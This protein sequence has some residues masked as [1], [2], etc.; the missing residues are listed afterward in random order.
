MHADDFAAPRRPAS[1][2]HSF[3]QADFRDPRAALARWHCPS[4]FNIAS[5]LQA[6]AEIRRASPALIEWNDNRSSL[7]TAEPAPDA[8]DASD[9]DSAMHAQQT[10][11]TFGEVIA[12][13]VVFAERMRAS[14]IGKGDVVGYRLK[15]GLP[16]A[17]LLLGIFRLGA[18]AM[19][20]F[21]LLGEDALAHRLRYSAAT[22]FLHDRD[23]RH[24]QVYASLKHAFEAVEFA[25]IEA[26]IPDRQGL[27]SEA[28]SD[29]GTPYPSLASD[30]A[31]LLFTSGTTGMP[32]GAL[33]PHSTLIGHLP[34]FEM[35]HH[36]YGFVATDQ[37]R[38]A[39]CFWT[40]ADWA[41]AGGMLDALLP[42]LYFGTP[43][44]I[45]AAPP[46]YFDPT[47]AEAMM[48]ACQVRNVF[49]P[50]AAL[51]KWYALRK[52]SMANSKLSLRSIASGGEGLP[53]ALMRWATDYFGVPVNEFYG[54]SECN[55]IIAS[56]H[57]QGIGQAGKLGRAVPTHTLMVIDEN[58]HPVQPGCP[59]ELAIKCPD[60]VMF[61]GYLDDATNTDRK[62][63]L[64]DGARW[65]RTGDLFDCNHDGYYTYHG[66][67]D[68]LLNVRG[69]RIGPAEIE[70]AVLNDASATVLA[71]S[72]LTI[73]AVAAVAMHDPE[74]GEGIRVHVVLANTNNR[75]LTGDSTQNS[76]EKDANAEGTASPE[77]GRDHEIDLV[78]LADQIKE[79]VGTRVGR[80]AR[81]WEVVFCDTLPSTI[82]GK[83]QR[84][85]L[86]NAPR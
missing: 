44:V 62:H 27:A 39:D 69:Y 80:H 56:C 5:A 76:A 65:L 67:I 32:K 59:G 22:L 66:R 83:I 9:A 21:R 52:E 18:V 42:A 2:Q 30:P 8:P 38:H 4:H 55:L 40:P 64:I 6:T 77:E 15:Q 68:E 63:M 10:T 24:T 3:A 74:R 46:S 73:E 33:L 60:P 82:T 36:G 16:A 43:T 71:A 45:D 49:L 41:W 17:A 29:W 58:N 14:G 31:V 47:R 84:R 72:S 86:Q 12:L 85:G 37:T 19:P 70:H 57:Q 50:P 51:R 81:P 26:W 35:S 23:F 78:R 61:L 75:G 13:S 34:G 20:M 7:L 48:A 11:W 25:S 79:I 1:A 28:A 53:P 54:Q